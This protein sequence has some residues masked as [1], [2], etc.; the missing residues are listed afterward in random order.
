MFEYSQYQTGA[1]IEAAAHLCKSMA[2][3]SINWSGG[4]HHA[5]RNM[6]SGFCYV[7]DI[8]LAIL[9]LLKTFKRV[10]Y[11]DIDVHH[12]DGVEDAFK[13]NDRVMTVSFHQYG[14]FFPNTGNV[15]SVG[16][17]KGKGYTVNVP[18]KYGIDDENYFRTFKTIIS[19]VFEVYQPEVTVMQ[20]GADS[21]AHDKLGQFNLTLRGHGAC[22]EL[23]RNF[24]T[25]L[26]LLGGGGYT[27]KNTAL[28]WANETAIA[29]GVTLPISKFSY[30]LLLNL[31]F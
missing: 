24:N 28:C 11:I 8:V 16:A 14:D 7:N 17:R 27:V 23:V 3:I 5:A 20:C 31:I 9:E 10:L 4:M 25:P 1:S 21:L 19:K 13:F 2:D 12:G 26:L 6:A 30:I 15:S 18:L 22:V 29:A